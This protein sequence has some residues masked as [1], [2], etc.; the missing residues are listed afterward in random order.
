MTDRLASSQPASGKPAQLTRTG[1]QQLRRTAQAL[2]ETARPEILARIT[3][4]RLYMDPAQG[5]ETVAAGERDLTV[6][7]GQ[8]AELEAALENAQVVGDGPAPSTVQLGF[9][10]T[11]KDADGESRTLTI[12]S[13][14]E[15][16]P[17]RGFISSES[18]AARALLGRAPGDHVTVDADGQ[19][20][21]LQIEKIGLAS[22]NLTA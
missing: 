3:Q 5:V 10:V 15:A 17:S 7:D 11:V 12:V 16:D 21:T 22:A 13:P 9:P 20:V 4:G 6:I 1:L 18:P 19:R 2:R 8:I 14:L